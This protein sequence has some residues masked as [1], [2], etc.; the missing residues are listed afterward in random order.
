M[1]LSELKMFRNGRMVM[2]EQLS[3]ETI[4]L[5]TRSS[6]SDNHGKNG[7]PRFPRECQAASGKAKA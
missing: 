3:L 2:E 4:K 7:R 6:P 5:Q 1:V